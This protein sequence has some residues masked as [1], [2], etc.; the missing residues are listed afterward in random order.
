LLEAVTALSFL[1]RVLTGGITGLL[2]LRLAGKTGVFNIMDL[3]NSGTCSFIATGDLR[4]GGGRTALSRCPAGG[5]A[6][7]VVAAIYLVGIKRKLELAC[8]FS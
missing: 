8:W 4:R 7:T 3:A 2:A 6:A 5:T 1:M